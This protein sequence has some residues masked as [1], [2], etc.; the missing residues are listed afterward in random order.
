[1][2]LFYFAF[3]VLIFSPIQGFASEDAYV[4]QCLKVHYPH[5]TDEFLKNNPA[6]SYLCQCFYREVTEAPLHKAALE[7]QYQRQRKNGEANLEHIN[8]KL[9]SDPN[10]SDGLVNKICNIRESHALHIQAVHTQEFKK[11]AEAHNLRES[12]TLDNLTKKERLTFSR[13][14][15]REIV[16]DF[17]ERGRDVQKKIHELLHQDKVSTPSYRMLYDRAQPCKSQLELKKIEED[18]A[19]KIAPLSPESLA[20]KAPELLETFGRGSGEQHL[21]SRRCSHAIRAKKFP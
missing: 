20:A 12:A 14:L 19:E 3:V 16:N 21:I 17:T 1:M 8:K 5:T 10:V 2:R 7:E 9:S 15:S 11:H 6:R 13:S 4:K 18:F